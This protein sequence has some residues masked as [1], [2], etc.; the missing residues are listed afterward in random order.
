MNQ[1][2]GTVPVPGQTVC[3][4]RQ[5]GGA[6]GTRVQRTGS[7]EHGMSASGSA[8]VG[9][10]KKGSAVRSAVNTRQFFYSSIKDRIQQIRLNARV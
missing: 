8:A 10:P 2:D 4:T 1:M 5:R 6:P 7:R 9:G 3:R